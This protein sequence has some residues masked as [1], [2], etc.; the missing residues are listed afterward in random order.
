[1]ETRQNLR[2]DLTASPID[3]GE[4]LAAVQ[5]PQAGATVLFLGTTRQFTG[6]RQT[7]SLAYEAYEAMARRQLGDMADEAARRWG[8]CG[9]AVVHRLGE[10]A[11]GETSVAIAVSAAHRDAAFD[12]GKW[13]ID[14][15]KQVV[16]IWKEECL[17]DGSRQWVHPGLTAP[18]EVSPSAAGP[19][20]TQ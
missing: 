8:L 3:V 9:C 16:P 18:S 10:I 7:L 13:L 12:A 4:V 2:I 11:V 15:I 20:A 14:R 6:P 5:S 17:V 19:E 1:M